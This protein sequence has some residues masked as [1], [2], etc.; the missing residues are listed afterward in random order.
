MRVSIVLSGPITPAKAR[1]FLSRAR[2]DDEVVIIDG[3]R[4]ATTGKA[5]SPWPDDPRLRRIQHEET[6]S[7][8]VLDAVQGDAVMIV[9]PGDQLMADT[10]G[11][12]A[13][14]LDHPEL[15]MVGCRAYEKKTGRPL[16]PMRHVSLVT[17]RNDVNVLD[18]PIAARASLTSVTELVPSPTCFLARTSALSPEALEGFD[19]DPATSLVA[20]PIRLLRAA[21]QHGKLALIP[22]E[23]VFVPL[24][25]GEQVRELRG[26]PSTVAF[27]WEMLENE[28]GLS[29]LDLRRAFGT[30]L[31]RVSLLPILE[32]DA[33]RQQ[34]IR[35]ALHALAGRIR[36]LRPDS[37]GLPGPS[38]VPG[39]RYV[40]ATDD[41]P[42]RADDLVSAWVSATAERTDVELLL[43]DQGG[44]EG[45]LATA[46]K[47]AD[48][49]GVPPSITL[50]PH[51][52][53]ITIRVPAVFLGTG[54]TGEMVRQALVEWDR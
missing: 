27:W 19:A 26:G 37:I 30:L 41:W 20:G 24:M 42:E 6:F 50:L 33:D 40:I 8:A 46:I 43:P 12:L 38:L 47:R 34:W 36:E 45:H 15:A 4:T 31:R 48:L 21:L 32:S 23:L 51:A 13:A 39:R 10:L 25:S 18:G 7:T 1:H 53:A 35:S 49:D 54:D 5:R 16:D 9:R 52:S 3:P 17:R 11:I 2:P 14:S 44:G 28:P 22:R 29:D